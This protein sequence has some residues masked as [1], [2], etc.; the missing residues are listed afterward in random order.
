M[1]SN[2]FGPYKCQ[3]NTIRSRSV[4]SLTAEA[5]GLMGVQAPE[6]MIPDKKAPVL[7]T[8]I[9]PDC[10]GRCGTAYRKPSSSLWER[11]DVQVVDSKLSSFHERH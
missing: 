10:P 6:E 7:D 4:L 1:R 9:S 2:K 11:G 3:L 8:K 5:R